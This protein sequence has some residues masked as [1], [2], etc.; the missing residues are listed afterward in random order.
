VRT[1]QTERLRGAA[2]APAEER[3]QVR[4]NLRFFQRTGLVGGLLGILSDLTTGEMARAAIIAFAMIVLVW[5]MWLRQRGRLRLSAAVFLIL[6]IT[7][8]HALCAV[9]DGI[10][11]TAIILYPVAILCAALML[12]RGLVIAVTVGCMTSVVITVALGRP[13]AGNWA[14]AFNVSL[15]LTVNAVAV[16]LLLRGVVLGAAEARAKERRLAQAYRELEARNTELERF[17]HVVSHDLKSPLVTI[18][19]FLDY[20]ERDA[21]AGNTERLEDDIERI[22]VATD[23]MGRLLDELLELSRTG[24]IERPP[25]A[26]PF[27]ELVREARA[28]VEGRLSSRGVQ[29]ELTEDAAARIVHGDRARLVEMLQNLLDNA[30]KFAGEQPQPRVV[31]GV[32]DDPDRDDPVFSVNDNGLGIEPAHQERVFELFK[33]LDPQTEGTGLGLALGRRIVEAH[34]GR[35]WV[36]SGGPGRGSTF[37]FTLPS[38]ERAD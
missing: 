4:H 19:G 14:D 35:L 15:T 38:G 33:Q 2:A 25:E 21:R 9:G 16:H 22:R 28:L 13:G 37:H 18:R 34:G 11:D 26:L 1:E 29:V 31:I 8:I 32:R 20:V 36:E 10:R 27:G 6:F 24:R 17:T 7:V 12:D 23:R 30:A 5:S 3:E